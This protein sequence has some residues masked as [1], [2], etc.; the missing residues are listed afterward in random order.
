[1]KEITNILRIS[2]EEQLFCSAPWSCGKKMVL[3]LAPK[4]FNWM[5]D[6][7][8]KFCKAVELAVS[9][10]AGTLATVKIWLLLSQHRRFVKRDNGAIR[11]MESL[12]LLV[13]VLNW[14]SVDPECNLVSKWNLVEYCKIFIMDMKA[15][16]S[17]WTVDNWIVLTGLIPLHMFSG[18]RMNFVGKIYKHAE[19]QEN[20]GHTSLLRLADKWKVWFY[21]MDGESVF[22]LDRLT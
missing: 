15:I 22:V 1:M 19:L 6:V 21:G 13:N 9:T 20:C 5:M 11:F 14:Q 8:F 10:C 7:T 3:R 17:K 2:A 4:T 12:L 18:Y 16:L